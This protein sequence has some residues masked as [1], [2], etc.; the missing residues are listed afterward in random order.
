MLG[1]F[2]VVVVVV[3]GVVVVVVVSIFIHYFGYSGARL[4]MIFN[5]SRGN[6]NGLISGQCIS[7]LAIKLCCN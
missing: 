6:K 1:R 7:S 5:S 2:V 4:F 3:V